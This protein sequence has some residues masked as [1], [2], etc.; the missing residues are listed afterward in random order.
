M[1]VRGYCTPKTWFLQSLSLLLVS[2]CFV[3]T[4]PI[5]AQPSSRRDAMRQKAQ[6]NMRIA[7]EQYQRGLYKEAEYSL[8]RIEDDYSSFMTTED[9]ELLSERLMQVKTALSER[10][11]IAEYL[12]AS[13]EFIANNQFSEAKSRLESILQSRFLTDAERSQVQVILDDVDTK[14]A[15]AAQSR[16]PSAAMQRSSTTMQHPSRGN[17]YTLL[18][19]RSIKLYNEGKLYDARAGFVEVSRS[20]FSVSDNGRTADDYINMINN[21]SVQTGPAETMGFQQQ[22]P[23]KEN[24]FGVEEWERPETML[25][26]PEAKE[27]A[28]AWRQPVQQP[29]KVT[30]PQV[31]TRAFEKV[32][33]YAGTSQPRERGYIHQIQQKKN[34]QINYT[35]AIVND[36]VTK[37]QDFVTKNEFDKAKQSLGRAVSMVSK[38]KLLL[39]D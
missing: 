15:L 3:S 29:V 19:E 14:L 18:F 12:G 9:Q 10:E 25:L 35:R 4:S 6:W 16:R 20:G 34:R 33:P 37:A 13:D 38:N 5:F 21:A 22:Q 17:Y 27:P 2:F 26:R 39:G 30:A 31:P 32:D 36:A 23:V 28:R 1:V 24:L 7:T 11:K 8:L